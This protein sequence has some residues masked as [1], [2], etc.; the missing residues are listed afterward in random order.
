MA[1][2]N[3]I[4]ENIAETKL[5]NAKLDKINYSEISAQINANNSN[6]AKYN[7]VK[8]KYTQFIDSNGNY[9]ENMANMNTINEM[10]SDSDLLNIQQKYQN[11]FWSILAIGTIV[12][13]ISNI[14]K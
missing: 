3:S 5:I 12:F 6:Y 2:M 7:T 13:T 11:I 10:L 8:E 14:K 4:E 1:N 9:N